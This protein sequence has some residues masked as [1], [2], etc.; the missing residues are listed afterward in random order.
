M[1]IGDFEIKCTK[2]GSEK[3]SMITYYKFY[4]TGALIKCKECGAK[5]RI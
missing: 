3:V 4:E 2:C 5:T 1:K